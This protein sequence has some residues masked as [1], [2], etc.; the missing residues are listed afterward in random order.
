M[1]QHKLSRWQDTGCFSTCKVG[2]FQFS[3]CPLRHE[4]YRGVLINDRRKRIH[5]RKT[6]LGC[7][8]YSK[9]CIERIA[10]LCSSFQGV[11][12][13]LKIESI[14]SR[15]IASTIQAQIG[16]LKH[17]CSCLRSKLA[18]S[19]RLCTVPMCLP[20]YLCVG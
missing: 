11:N 17:L 18:I 7:F 1:R 14:Y 3:V 2:K 10:Q 4:W 9:H 19:N 5:S 20:L 8:F 12:I 15:H 13:E 6:S 16:M